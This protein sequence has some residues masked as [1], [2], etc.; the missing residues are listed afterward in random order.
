MRVK[1]LAPERAIRREALI[2]RRHVTALR[3]ERRR[4]VVQ[5]VRRAC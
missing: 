1:R 4:R 2:V 3:A 5:Q